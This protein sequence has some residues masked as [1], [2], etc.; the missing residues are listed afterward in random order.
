MNTLETHT[1]TLDV[2]NRQKKTKTLDEK[3]R[4]TDRERE[5]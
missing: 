5:K 1:E 4:Q 3:E 2:T